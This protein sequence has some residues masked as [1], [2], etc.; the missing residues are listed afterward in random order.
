MVKEGTINGLVGPSGGGKS[1][2]AQLLLRFYEPQQGSVKIGGVDIRD[3]SPEKLMD[4]IS[5]VFQD[6]FLFRGTIENNIRMGNEKADFKEVEKAA[7]NANIHDVIM[8][9]PQSYSTVVGEKDV[10]LSG[11]KNSVLLLRGYF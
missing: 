6:S 5:Y 9:L 3:I 4:I 10:Y 11:E 1:T 8:S 2:L 7:K